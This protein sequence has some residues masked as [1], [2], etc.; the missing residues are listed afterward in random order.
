M[1]EQKFPPLS[2]VVQDKG[3]THPGSEETFLGSLTSTLH[4]I[5][6]RRKIEANNFCPA[7]PGEQKVPPKYFQ[8]AGAA[9]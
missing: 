7:Y 6:N 3:F 5:A 9:P 2:S 8:A 1:F 4:S